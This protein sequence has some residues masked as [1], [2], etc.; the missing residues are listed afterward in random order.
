[1][2][3]LLLTSNI[4]D[5]DSEADFS[6]S[7]K[8]DLTFSN[9][10]ELNVSDKKHFFTSV[11]TCTCLLVH[12]KELQSLQMLFNNW[13][14]L[15]LPFVAPETELAVMPSP[16]SSVFQHSAAICPT[17][18]HAKHCRLEFLFCP[19]CRG[20]GLLRLCPVNCLF[21]AFVD[22]LLP[23]DAAFRWSFPLPSP[24]VRNWRFL[25]KNTEVLKSFTI[26]MDLSIASSNLLRPDI[27]KSM[28]SSE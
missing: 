7:F 20:I 4:F 10:K 5:N 18:W 21:W 2:L 28:P 16:Y 6:V 25:W 9:H 3:S 1:M 22:G 26:P 23:S 15:K 13:N 11:F 8:P 14:L 19:G 17:I 24:L 12:V 27:D